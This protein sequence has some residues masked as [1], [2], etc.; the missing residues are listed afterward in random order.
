MAHKVRPLALMGRA[1]MGLDLTAPLEPNGPG[2]TVLGLHGRP[3]TFKGWILMGQALLSLWA[4]M[5][6]PGP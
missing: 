2:P 5:A 3:L 1:L 6:P 4:L